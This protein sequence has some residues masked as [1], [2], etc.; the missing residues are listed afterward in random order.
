ME[1]ANG[2]HLCLL[3]TD[4]KEKC[5]VKFGIT[6]MNS[7]FLLLSF[8]ELNSLLFF[9]PFFI[10]LLCKRL[11][12]IPFLILFSD[13]LPG[14][15]YKAA[16]PF[17]SKLAGFSSLCSANTTLRWRSSLARNDMDMRSGHCLGRQALAGLWAKYKKETWAYVNFCCLK[18]FSFRPFN[19]VQELAWE[20]LDRHTY[21]FL[22]LAEYFI[23]LKSLKNIIPTMHPLLKM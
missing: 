9:F 15:K 4:F 20:W 14:P 7:H 17:Y 11:F 16:S 2:S 18:M 22:M 19:A 21:R 23:F 13:C 1:T 12:W 5:S 8:Q 10:Y 3:M 6:E